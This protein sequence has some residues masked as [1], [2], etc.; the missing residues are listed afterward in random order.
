VILD[1]MTIEAMG[2]APGSMPVA[3]DEDRIAHKGM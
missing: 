1:V 3:T 2:F